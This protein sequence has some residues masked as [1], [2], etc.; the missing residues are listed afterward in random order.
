[1]HRTTA[2]IMA[3]GMGE[4]FGNSEPKQFCLLKGQPCLVWVVK[5]ISEHTA[6]Q[7]IVVVVP[8]GYESRVEEMVRGLSKVEAVVTGGATRQ[9]SARLG[10]DSIRGPAEYVLV[11][12]AVRPCFSQAL[13]DRVIDTLGE[14]EAVVPV[15]P[16]V[17]TLYREADGSVDAVLDRA[18]IVHVQTPQG[19]KTELLRKAHAEAAAKGFISSDDGSLVFFL[20]GRVTTVQG[21]RN[22]LKITF[23]EDLKLA[24]ALISQDW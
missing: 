20:G 8:K 16:A 22:N 6:V 23:E 17:D 14:N 12:D 7:R 11:H 2:L 21:E 10:L 19:F 18:H 15:E 4:R 13:L 5:K 24:E 3:A 1:M 9:E